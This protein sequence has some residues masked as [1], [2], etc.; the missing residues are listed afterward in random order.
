MGE[1]FCTIFLLSLAA[2]GTRPFGVHAITEVLAEGVGRTIDC[3]RPL[4][5][6]LNITSARYGTGTCESPGALQTLQTRCGG[7][8]TCSVRAGDDVFGDSCSGQSRLEFS[9]DCL[10]LP[11]YHGC[12]RDYRYYRALRGTRLTSDSLTIQDCLK[13]CRNRNYKYAGV[14]YTYE[15]FCGNNE[16]FGRH[17][18]KPMSDCNYR[19]NGDNEQYC[20]GS[21]RIEVYESSMGQY[22]ADLTLDGSLH[23]VYSPDF[24]G[25]YPRSK[26]CQW[27][28][29]AQNDKVVK[30]QFDLFNLASGDVIEVRDG[31]EE[32]Q[33]LGLT[34]I[35]HCG[36][37]HLPSNSGAVADPYTGNVGVGETALVICNNRRLVWV[38]CEEDQRF[39]DTGP[40]CQEDTTSTAISSTALST[41]MSHHSL[42]TQEGFSTS[43]YPPNNAG[44][45]GQGTGST[46]T[47]I[48]VGVA[49]PLVVIATVVVAIVLC[50]RNR[51]T[52]S[53]SPGLGQASH[54]DSR[55]SAPPSG[56]VGLSSL[57]ARY[58]ANGGAEDLDPS[59]HLYAV[60]DDDRASKAAKPGRG[61]Q[62]KNRPPSPLLSQNQDEGFT[63]ND[64]YETADDVTTEV[65]CES[66]A[67][68]GWNSACANGT[69]SCHGGFSSSDGTFCTDDL[70]GGGHCITCYDAVRCR[71]CVQVVL[72][73]SGRCVTTCRSQESLHLAGD[74]YLGRVCA[75]PEFESLPVGYIAVIGVLGGL[76][77]VA[78]L[79]VM[80]CCIYTKRTKG[81]LN[82]LRAWQSTNVEMTNMNGNGSRAA[83]SIQYGFNNPAFLDDSSLSVALPDPTQALT[84]RQV[85]QHK[86]EFFRLATQ[87]R[88]HVQAF[89][90]MLGDARRRLR[91]IGEEHK[92]AHVYRI[93][94]RDLSRVVLVLNRAEGSSVEIPRDGVAL[95]RWA[96]HALAAYRA[97]AAPSDPAH[98]SRTP[99]VAGS[100]RVPPNV[101]F[102]SPPTP[103]RTNPYVTRHHSNRS[104][105]MA[106]GVVIGNGHASVSFV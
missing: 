1:R 33:D 56:S 7:R 12:F 52:T 2:V 96:R 3:P 98:V 91:N 45:Q 76:I 55:A 66:S 30:L 36:P 71:R 39:N 70:C 92:D 67:D 31:T 73:A 69:C 85:Q 74:G 97:Q 43:L 26:T 37:I 54:L 81:R 82:F 15:C 105:S 53:K 29:R 41:R 63:E 13:S 16:D 8:S 48:A 44:Q 90:T 28:I 62:N 104:A 24:P 40:Y 4:V 25:L 87:L 10:N 5:Q 9:Y 38:R 89:L 59:E 19:C 78:A 32:S 95:M 99:S 72:S 49:V 22:G 21:L 35:G 42:A 23:Y 84:P 88:P 101:S 75:D 79:V 80:A 102:K 68:C 77:L 11:G 6:R 64:L 17:G 46:V 18:E 106:N 94:I 14:E 83:A 51:N 60:P 57:G 100:T 103:V 58:V 61:D 50:R 65:M 20:G 34:E 47:F 93:I 86:A 27:T